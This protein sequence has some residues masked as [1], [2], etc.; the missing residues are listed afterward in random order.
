MH[1][2]LL[3]ALLAP[4]PALAAPADPAFEPASVPA[5]GEHAAW[6]RIPRAGRY[7]L[8]AHSPHGVR[9]TLVDPMTGPGETAGRP[10]GVD[11]RLDVLLDAGTYRVDVA[12]PKLGEGVAT[13]DVRA[14]TDVG[15]D[16]LRL[17]EGATAEG[18]LADGEARGWWIHIPER[19]GVA[20]EA[21]GAGLADLRI[22]KDGQWLVDALPGCALASVT[23]GEPRRQCGLSTLLEPG[24]Y[25]VVAYGG[26]LVD[27]S[28]A[29]APGRDRVVVRASLPRLAMAGTRRIEVGPLGVERFR[30]PEGAGLVVVDLD[31]VV[32]ATLGVRPYDVVRALAPPTASQTLRVDARRPTLAVT[33]RLRDAVISFTA[34][35]G[36]AGTLRWL[37]P[38]AG[39]LRLEPGTWFA[40]LAHTAGPE[41]AP[42]TGVWIRTG[43]DGRA[44]V[45]ATDAVPLGPAGIDSRFNLA[46]STSV[47]A[48]VT[49]EGPYRLELEGGR[50]RVEPWWLTP[51]VGYTP[52]PLVPLVEQTLAPGLYRVTLE[53]DQPGQVRWTVSGSAPGPIAPRKLR[54][55]VMQVAEK[56]TLSL[57]ASAPPGVQ[58]A[59]VRRSL[60]VAVGAGI[61]LR[62]GPGERVSLPVLAAEGVVVATRA[63]GSRLSVSVGGSPFGESAPARAGFLVVH[64]D[65]D[66]PTDAEV[67]VVPEAVAVGSIPA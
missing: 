19:R 8:E 67:R 51:P 44:E 48:E 32:P 22:W 28:Q 27:W 4:W 45:A 64:N 23:P 3:L 24:L 12:G 30:V 58:V 46:G 50:L 57:F 59:L 47:V 56:T 17:E 15:P 13:L 25:R 53:P 52:P 36:T 41:D 9:L 62:L 7:T 63:D 33:T 16:D 61:P 14:F 39:P 54:W 43:P 18:T 29:G 34:P 55:D 5:T 1:R 11:G 21:A 40:T 38:D 66:Q 6:L 65:R 42:V 2:L 26:P 20:I 10:G 31:A 35:P 49:E 37:P 60:P